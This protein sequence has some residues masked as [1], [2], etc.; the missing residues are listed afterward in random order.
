MLNAMTFL[1]SWND[2][3]N[4]NDALFWAHWLMMP[5]RFTLPDRGARPGES[6][7]LEEHHK[8]MP[9]AEKIEF[10]LQTLMDR[11]PPSHAALQTVMHA[12]RVRDALPA[13]AS[14][15][16]EHAAEALVMAG[17]LDALYE[18]GSQIVRL[19]VQQA[20]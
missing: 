13:E 10:N 7:Q 17:E 1:D 2:G 11:V 20:L 4:R 15:H 16:Q 14:E 19:R 8:T 5:G 12:L 9:T 18:Y 6:W 3:K